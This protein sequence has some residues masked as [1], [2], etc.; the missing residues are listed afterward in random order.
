D[1]EVRVLRGR[2]DEYDGAVLHPG[3]KR[4]LLS[5]VEPVDLVDEEDRAP[6]QSSLLLRCGHGRPDVLNAC[7]HRVQGDELR[8]CRVGDHPGERGL[9]RAW[10]PIE[11][12]RAQLVGLY[13][14]PKQSSWADD[15]VLADELVEGAG[16]H[17]SGQRLMALAGE[18]SRL[19]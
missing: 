8:F 18:Q 12:H 19:R 14:P 6:T 1:L 17:A 3:Q 13:G 7:Q 15:P 2:A 10:G 16:P 4:V 5:L 9:A 11:D